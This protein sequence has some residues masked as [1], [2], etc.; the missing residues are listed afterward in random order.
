MYALTVVF[1][2]GP[3]NAWQFM[4]KDK[5]KALA[6]R[7]VATSRMGL[8][9]NAEP[10]HIEDD[11]GQEAAFAAGKV[12]AVNLEDYEHP[13]MKKIMAQRRAA[14]LGAGMAIP[15]PRPGFMS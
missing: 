4:F 9:M 1:G 11:L 3:A 5:E 6:A 14:H 15:G 2:E 12:I 8:G 7:A 13:E 10:G